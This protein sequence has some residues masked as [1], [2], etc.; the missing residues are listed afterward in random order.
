MSDIVLDTVGSRVLRTS[1]EGLSLLVL[2]TADVT[3]WIA[4]DQTVV[5]I[6]LHQ[7][8]IQLKSRIVILPGARDILGNVGRPELALEWPTEREVPSSVWVA[9]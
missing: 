7:S 5:T 1:R 9:T 8:R 2:P 3:D 6:S 4:L